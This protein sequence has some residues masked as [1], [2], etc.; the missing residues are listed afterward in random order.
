MILH[1][2]GKPLLCSSATTTFSSY[3]LLPFPFLLCYY[4]LNRHGYGDIAPLVQMSLVW[5]VEWNVTKK[6]RMI[7][8]VGLPHPKLFLSP[9]GS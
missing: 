5:E 2:K 3:L 4:A 8:Q 1:F 7:A 9:I 6:L